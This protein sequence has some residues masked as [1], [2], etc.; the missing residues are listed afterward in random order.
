MLVLG[1]LE[2]SVELRL[3]RLLGLLDKVLLAVLDGES[4]SI[5]HSDGWIIGGEASEDW[6]LFFFLFLR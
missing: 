2:V 6:G 1:N 5:S 3:V 4:G